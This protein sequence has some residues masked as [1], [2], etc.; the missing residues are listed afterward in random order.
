MLGL[1]WFAGPVDPGIPPETMFEWSPE[2]GTELY[3]YEL[4]ISP[5]GFTKL[6]CL[7]RKARS[8]RENLPSTKTWSI[9]RITKMGVKSTV[10]STSEFEPIPFFR[11]T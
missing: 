4:Y 7:R 9:T 11:S 6:P 2:L 8:F 1:C 5:L 10:V 3:M